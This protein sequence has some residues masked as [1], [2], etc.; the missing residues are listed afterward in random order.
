[1]LRKAGSIRKATA[2][3]SVVDLPS[4]PPPHPN[5]ENDRLKGDDA[6]CNDDNGEGGIPMNS[7]SASS[8]WKRL[9]KDTFIGPNNEIRTKH[10]PELK[11]R[12]N[13]VQLLRGAKLKHAR[14]DGTATT[15]S[16]RHEPVSISDRAYNAFCRAESRQSGTKKGVRTQGHGRAENMNAGKTRGGAMDGGC[17]CRSPRRSTP[18]SSPASTGS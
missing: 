3:R 9:D 6:D 12:Q 5:Y 1:M 18:A 4:H 7:Q 10:D 17:G 14:N 15:A 2:G 16:D 8:S 13:A 11:H